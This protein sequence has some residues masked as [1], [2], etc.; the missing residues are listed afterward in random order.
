M[1]ITLKAVVSTSETLEPWQEQLLGRVFRCPVANEYGARDA[2]I[3]AYR[4][5]EG[6]MHIT[7]EN[8]VIE[9]LSPKTHEPLGVG[10]SGVLAV[11][12]LHNLSSRGCGIC[13]GT[14]PEFRVKHAAAGGHCHYSR[15]SRGEKMICFWG[16]TACWSTVILSGSCC[17]RCRA[18]A[19]SS[20]GRNRSTKPGLLLVR[21]TPDAIIDE[22][23]ILAQLKKVLPDTVVA[24][25]YV[26]EITPTT[27]GKLRYAI[28]ECPLPDGRK[29][30]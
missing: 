8:C 4:C 12:D 10:E 5:P 20:S 17:A 21:Q 23:S 18:W 22:A 1:K 30:S 28:R 2:G 26:D 29:T 6:C 25:E 15:M 9:V 19:R 14:L 16:T 3:L 11:T 13:L 7:A 24:I 27:S